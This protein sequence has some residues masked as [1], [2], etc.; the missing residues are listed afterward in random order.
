MVHRSD[1]ATLVGALLRV[2]ADPNENVCARSLPIVDE[3]L[4]RV[5]LGGPEAEERGESGRMGED[6]GTSWRDSRLIARLSWVPRSFDGVVLWRRPRSWEKSLVTS[7]ASLLHRKY[8][9]Q[10]MKGERQEREETYT[11]RRYFEKLILT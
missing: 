6:S 9:S 5:E 7:T 1:A 4:R 10:R 3:T 8:Q 11:M 2:V